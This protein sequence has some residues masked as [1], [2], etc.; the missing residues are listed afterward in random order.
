[1]QNSSQYLYNLN[2]SEINPNIVAL[3]IN[4]T[5]IIKY[6]GNNISIS[7]LLN[8]YSYYLPDKFEKEKIKEIKTA[9]QLLSLEELP[10]DPKL[11]IKIKEKLL[12]KLSS[13]L[14]KNVTSLDVIFVIENGRFGNS[15]IALN[16]I[17]FYCELLGCKKIILNENKYWHIKKEIISPK[18]NLTIKIG[19]LIDNKDENIMIYNFG[20]FNFFFIPQIIRTQIR[21]DLVKNEILNNLPKVNINKNSLYI[22]IRSGDIFSSSIASNYGQPPLCFYEKIIKN[23]NFKK[24]FII[25][26]DKYNQ[27]INELINK[28]NN[29]IY[30]K[31]SLDIDIAYLVNAKN[32]VASIS[33]FLIMCIKLNDNLKYLWEYDFTRLSI[34]VIH[35]HHHIYKYPIKYKTYTMMPSKKYIEE[36]FYWEK[37]VEQVKLM[38]EEICPYDFTIT[39]PNR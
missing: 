9:N 31:N 1:M 35:L 17:I 25:S 5:K 7:N 14:N 20:I 22:H 33:S 10:K 39:F 13:Y 11:L 38:I 8:Y 30:T 36:M 3:Y 15:L 28:Y 4:N 6:K 26:K 34:K 23:F 37:T 24:I 16:N 27:N 19:K 32:I 29:I 21:I 2:V 12:N 18:T